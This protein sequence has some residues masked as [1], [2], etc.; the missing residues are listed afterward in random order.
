VLNLKD[1]IRGGERQH[2]VAWHIGHLV[3][4]LGY[5]LE[6]MVPVILPGNGFG[7]NGQLRVEFEIVA[8]LRRK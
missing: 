3:K 7:Q 6:D 1:H 5:T 2:V 4:K 8:L